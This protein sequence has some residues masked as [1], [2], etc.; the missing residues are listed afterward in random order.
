MP[1]AFDAEIGNLKAAL[2]PGKYLKFPEVLCSDIVNTPYNK[3]KLKNMVYEGISPS[4]DPRSGWSSAYVSKFGSEPSN[5]EA[6]L[7]DAMM[8]ASFALYSR[9]DSETLNEAIMGGATGAMVKCAMAGQP[10]I[11]RIHSPDWRPMTILT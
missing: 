4:A 10:Q 11:F 7:Y 9:R 8:L 6:Q 2:Q 3:G 5:G 1:E